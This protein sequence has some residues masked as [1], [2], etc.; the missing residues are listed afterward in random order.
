MFP[1]SP[2]STLN[3][4]QTN[5]ISARI[6]RL[7]GTVVSMTTS[8]LAFS[9]L[10]D[11]SPDTAM[12]QDSHNDPVLEPKHHPVETNV[13]S[14]NWVDEEQAGMLGNM[15]SRLATSAPSAAEDPEDENPEAAPH[16][17]PVPTTPQALYPYR[18]ENSL[19]LLFTGLF[20]KEI[21][22]LDSPSYLAEGQWSYKFSTGTSIGLLLMSS[23]QSMSVS[24]DDAK[25][26]FTTYAAGPLLG[27]DLLRTDDY[28]LVA[29]LSA[30]KGYLFVRRKPS[31][32]PETL[33]KSEY[34]F[35]EPA[36][37]FIFFPTR[38][39]DIGPVISYRSV[40][41]SHPMTVKP[42]DHGDNLPVSDVSVAT[43][44]DLTGLSVGITIRA[45][46]I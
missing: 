17:P 6:L 11:G 21:S 1:K 18:W 39:Y 45:V 14:R 19:D 13:G 7:F 42:G 9:A 36:L 26:R 34:I 33:Y 5:P 8:S 37:S 25:L 41:L 3:L 15:S 28:R 43:N 27:Q 10:I 20:G 4:T 31:S 16:S 24:R 12:K 46:K 38:H 30:G 23:L 44:K 32:G 2:P 22:D 29:S 35:Y 40:Q